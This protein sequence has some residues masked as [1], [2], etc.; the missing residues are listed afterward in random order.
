MEGP[1]L[2]APDFVA[3]R[4]RMIAVVVRRKM[5]RKTGV[6]TA[7]QPLAPLMEKKDVKTTLAIALGGGAV[8]LVLLSPMGLGWGI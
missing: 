4:V 3:G 5:G 6:L 7:P 2:T 1:G 8:E